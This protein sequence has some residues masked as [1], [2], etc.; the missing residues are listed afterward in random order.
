[1]VWFAVRKSVEAGAHYQSTTA[2]FDS[3][4]FAQAD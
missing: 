3:L 2:D 4:D 1:L